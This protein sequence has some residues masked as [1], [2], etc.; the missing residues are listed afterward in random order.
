[1]SPSNELK[2]SSSNERKISFEASIEK[3]K[4]LIANKLTVLI[5][6]FLKFMELQTNQKAESSTNGEGRTPG[7]RSNGGGGINQSFSTEALRPA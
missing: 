2:K 3:G 1:M 6:Q 7:V 4:N 5:E